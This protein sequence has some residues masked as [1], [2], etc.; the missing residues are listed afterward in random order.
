M[1]NRISMTN[2]FRIA[3]SKRP[4]PVGLGLCILLLVIAAAAPAFAHGGFDHLRGTV[5]K[6][7][8][9]VLTVKTD[10]GN[11]EVK[12]DNQTEL[13]RNGQKA[14]LADLKPGARVIVDVP[15][16]VKDRIAHSVRIGSLAKPVDSPGHASHK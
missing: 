2:R 12:L 14:Q 4:N 6:V 13:T 8:N 1:T 15:Q 16:G 10:K 7:G 3:T 9:N 11:V 5:V